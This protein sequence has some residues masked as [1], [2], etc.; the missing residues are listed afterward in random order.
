MSKILRVSGGE[1]VTVVVAPTDNRYVL[2]MQE[3]ERHVVAA[4]IMGRPGR[5]G[6]G[7][8]TYIQDHAPV[9]AAGSETWYNPVTLQ[10][11]VFTNGAWRPVS[12]DGGYF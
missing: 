8:V 9:G 5:D 12:P 1:S 11:K 10:M 4:G 7:G 3:A 2:N 6:A